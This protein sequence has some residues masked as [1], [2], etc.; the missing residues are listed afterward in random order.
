MK[1]ST[2]EQII[3]IAIRRFNKEGFAKVC[4][5]LGMP[6]DGN[7]PREKTGVKQQQGGDYRDYYDD[8]TKAKVAECF[9]REIKLMDYSF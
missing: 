6:Y 1:K 7:M 9:A 2:K 3:E 4:E 5:K 8:D